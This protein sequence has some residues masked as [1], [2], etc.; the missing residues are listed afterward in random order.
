MLLEKY[1]FIPIL[2]KVFIDKECDDFEMK[3]VASRAINNFIHR[4]QKDFLKET[5]LIKQL[6]EYVDKCLQPPEEEIDIN[7]K[8]DIRLNDDRTLKL[9]TRSLQLIKTSVV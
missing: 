8:I 6:C 4:N 1:K 7:S 3:M 9:A 5:D 2:S